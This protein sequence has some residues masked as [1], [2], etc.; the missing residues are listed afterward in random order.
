VAEHDHRAAAKAREPALDRAVVPERPIARERGI[1]LEQARD[2]VG[3]VRPLG[4]TRDLGLLPAVELGVSLPEQ[5]LGAGL[6]TLDLLGEVDLAAVREVAQLLDLAFELA[7]RF[8]EVQQRRELLP[9]GSS[10]GAR[11]DLLGLGD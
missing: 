4:M 3:K 1:V 11:R 5:L 8:F 2:V 6:E 10:A 7:D 9:A